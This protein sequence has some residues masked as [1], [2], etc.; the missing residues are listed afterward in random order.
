MIG[1]ANKKLMLIN[2]RSQ[3]LINISLLSSW[4]QANQPTSTI[5]VIRVRTLAQ[6]FRDVHI[7]PTHEGLIDSRIIAKNPDQ[8]NLFYSHSG[9][10]KVSLLFR[11]SEDSFQAASFHHY[12]DN[13]PHTLVIVLTVW[14]NNRR[15][16]QTFS[17]NF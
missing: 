15:V 10:Q 16:H 7:V 12:C 14:K 2:S 17:P 9:P 11:A 4:K 8:L 1:I 6:T 5:Q 3:F 13:I